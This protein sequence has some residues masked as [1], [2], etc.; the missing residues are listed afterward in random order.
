[1]T[2]RGSR[3]RRTAF[4]AWLDRVRGA[5]RR[6]RPVAEVCL[7]RR[8]GIGERTRSS[9]VIVEG[10]T[11]YVPETGRALQTGVV[12]PPGL[13][14]GSGPLVTYGWQEEPWGMADSDASAAE[15]P[16]REAT[17]QREA[18]EAAA[19]AVGPAAVEGQGRLVE[20]VPNGNATIASATSGEGAPCARGY[21]CLYEASYHLCAFVPVVGCN[22][23]SDEI[24][25]R[26]WTNG[27]QTWGTTGNQSAEF[28]GNNSPDRSA[29]DCTEYEG[30]GWVVTPNQCSWGG[31]N[32][33]FA[34]RGEHLYATDIFHVSFAGKGFISSSKHE[35]Q[36]MLDR[37]WWKVV[38]HR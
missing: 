14:E 22:L 12:T 21:N 10:G 36:F 33:A 25:V 18:A 26:W 4:Q 24:V 9:G 27:E 19:Q 3:G 6:R 5:D 35:I 31:S 38:V 34:S 11:S 1:M 28:E 30:N 20:S 15:A 16:G 23:W 13:P 37:W 17:R 29:V 2:A 7:A 8:R 32:P